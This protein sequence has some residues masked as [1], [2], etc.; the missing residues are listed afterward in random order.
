[1]N[2]KSSLGIYKRWKKG[3]EENMYDKR[4]SACLLFRARSNT[5]ALIDI[6]RHTDGEVACKLCGRDEAFP[7]DMAK[8]G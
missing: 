6:N 3:I 1:M 5:L 8:V 7:I 4:P 2:H